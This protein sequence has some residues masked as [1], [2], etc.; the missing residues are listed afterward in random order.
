M[1]I[2][3]VLS[4]PSVFWVGKESIN[5]FRFELI[6]LIRVYVNEGKEI[7]FCYK[8]QLNPRHRAHSRHIWLYNLHTAGI[9]PASRFIEKMSST[10]LV[11]GGN[12]ESPRIVSSGHFDTFSSIVSRTLG[13]NRGKICWNKIIH[14]LG[15]QVSH[16]HPIIFD[17]HTSAL[18]TSKYSS[19][20]NIIFISNLAILSISRCSHGEIHLVQCFMKMFR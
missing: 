8:S 13:T 18:T 7:I 17:P 20:M 10:D 6:I 15:S 2:I 16:F 4:F 9:I 11:R 12:A 5:C 19:H 3:E 1:K 14:P